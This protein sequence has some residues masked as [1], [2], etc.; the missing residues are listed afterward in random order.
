VLPVRIDFAGDGA[1][2]LDELLMRAVAKSAEQP[3]A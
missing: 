1:T 3:A 2:M